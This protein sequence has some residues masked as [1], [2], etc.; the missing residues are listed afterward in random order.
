MGQVIYFLSLEV[1]DERS[2]KFECTIFSTNLVIKGSYF[3]VILLY[4][5]LG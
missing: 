3:I 5:S 4:V 1:R 2:I